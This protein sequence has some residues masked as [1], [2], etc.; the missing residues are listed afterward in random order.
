MTYVKNI[1]FEETTNEE[2]DLTDSS[3]T[4]YTEPYFMLTALSK[5]EI[6]SYISKI[7]DNGILVKVIAT[8]YVSDDFE[9]AACVDESDSWYIE[10]DINDIDEE[11]ILFKLKTPSTQIFKCVVKLR[12]LENFNKLNGLGWLYFTA[13][14]N[15]SYYCDDSVYSNE[16]KGFNLPVAT[17]LTSDLIKIVEAIPD[18]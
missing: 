11:E 15:I 5:D 9:E 10:N 7:E 2:F 17:L 3:T 18:K 6:K 8:N 1:D 14:K 16:Y 13:Y 4:I 12:P